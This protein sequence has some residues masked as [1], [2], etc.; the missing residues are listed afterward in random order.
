MADV[1]LEYGCIS[2]NN[3]HLW[4]GYWIIILLIIQSKIYYYTKLVGMH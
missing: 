2:R 3:L 1:Y 4:V